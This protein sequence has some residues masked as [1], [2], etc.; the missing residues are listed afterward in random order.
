MRE[1]TFASRLLDLIPF[2]EE[3]AVSTKELASLLNCHWR[4]ITLTV[5]YLRRKGH[6]ICSCQRGF[7]KPER[8]DEIEHFVRTM[9]S[10][11]KHIKAAAASAEKL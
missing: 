2:G 5:H 10:R 1:Q 11:C 6:V 7:F 8:R 3:N 4:E 9:R